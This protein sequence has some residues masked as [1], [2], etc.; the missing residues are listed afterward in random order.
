MLDV[1]AGGDYLGDQVLTNTQ[2]RWE[3]TAKAVTPCTVLA[4]TRRSLQE[5]LDSSESLRSRLAQVRARPERYADSYRESAI[6]RGRRPRR[7][8]GPTRHLCGL[9]ARTAGGPPTPDDLDELLAVVW[10]EPS[11]FLA[12]PRTIAAF[13]TECT[14]RG[15]CP[16]AVE[17]AGHQLPAWRGVPMFPCNKLPVSGTNTSS[18]LLLRTGEECQGVVG[19][20]QTGIPDEYQ[21]SLSVRFMGDQREG[22]HLLPGQRLLLG[23]GAGPRRA[24]D[25]RE[26][27]D[28]PGS[29]SPQPFPLPEFYLPYPARRNCDLDRAVNV[30]NEL[31]TLRLRQFEELVAT[32]LPALCDE[33]ELSW[34]AREQ[35][36]RYVRGLQD[37]LA[38]D[39]EWS[40]RT[41]RYHDNWSQDGHAVRRTVG[42]PTETGGFSPRPLAAV[43]GGDQR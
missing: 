20:H 4:L 17:V 12:H 32:A 6:E 23:G 7:R 26:R 9:P 19:L 33:H 34:P 14:R 35:L 30:L 21:P 18:I 22:H 31:T 15:V 1:L 38:G 41:R 28:R 36:R 37:W 40:R 10:K 13:G 2:N 16:Q 11:F 24:R 39:L 27:R 43:I 8:A 42:N 25:P 5:L 29:M 3:F